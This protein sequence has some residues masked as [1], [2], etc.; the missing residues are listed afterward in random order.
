MNISKR[1]I[2]SFITL[3][4]LIPVVLSA[5]ILQCPMGTAKCKRFCLRVLDW[6]GTQAH[7]GTVTVTVH[8]TSW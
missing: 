1:L 8:Y 5:C 3:V 4:L 6:S 7:I 2:D